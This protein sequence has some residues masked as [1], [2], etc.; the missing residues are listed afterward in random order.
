[1]TGKTASRAK[2]VKHGLAGAGV[3]LPADVAEAVARRKAAWRGGYR[4]KTEEEEW[5]FEQVVVSSVRV[6]Q[7]QAEEPQARALVAL[8]AAAFWDDDRRLDAEALGARLAKN[9]ALVARKLGSSRQG[10]EWLLERWHGLAA[11]LES[12]RDWTEAERS[13]ALDLLGAPIELRGPMGAG[14]APD[15]EGDLAAARAAIERL[16]DKRDAVLGPLDEVA[17]EAAEVGF[18]LSPPR[19]VALL[20]RYEAACWNRYQWAREQ[21]P[22]RPEVRQPAA[23]PAS[24][25]PAARPPAGPDRA[26]DRA[27]LARLPAAAPRPE[28]EPEPI[29]DLPAAPGPA[30]APPAALAPA[31]PS[32]AVRLSGAALPPARPLNRRQRRAAARLAA[33]AR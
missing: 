5:L 30:S 2:S 20:R 19:P 8:R 6:E 22:G 14:D 3:V 12:G 28:A 25:R 23:D 26:L 16:E 17:R 32:P 29:P 33:R 15:R 11:A 24:A 27:R 7:C 21:L 4:L 9:P 10:C 13:L 31:A 18:E 1:V